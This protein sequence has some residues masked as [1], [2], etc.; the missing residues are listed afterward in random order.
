MTNATSTMKR[1]NM[2]QM[3]P[4]NAPVVVSYLALSHGTLIVKFLTE[5][6][7]HSCLPFILTSTHPQGLLILLPL[8]F[9]YFPSTAVISRWQFLPS[10]PYHL[11]SSHVVS[12]L[13]SCYI[14]KSILTCCWSDL[15]KMQI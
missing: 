9:V 13:Q 3:E 1:E 14:L 2:P 11:V 4:S 12:Y 15:C 6:H 8:V 5:M 7:G 10:Y